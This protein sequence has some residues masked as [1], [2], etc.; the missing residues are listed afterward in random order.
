MG[1]SLFS[2]GNMSVEA[3]SV[4]RNEASMGPSLFS[5]G[6]L[7]DDDR[8]MADSI[9]LQWGRRYSATEIVVATVATFSMARL[10]WGRRYSATEIMM[11]RWHRDQRKIASMGPSLFSDG[12]QSG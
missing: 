8:A 11:R 9:E 7:S 2:D 10:Q 5:D 4:M 6:N 12:N 1:P 3:V